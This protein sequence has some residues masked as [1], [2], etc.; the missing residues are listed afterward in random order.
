VQKKDIVP[1][2]F[3]ISHMPES[4]HTSLNRETGPDRGGEERRGKECPPLLALLL[5]GFGG[6]LLQGLDGGLVGLDFAAVGF[7]L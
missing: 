1:L 7:D 5:G 2:L 3:I 4:D 6:F